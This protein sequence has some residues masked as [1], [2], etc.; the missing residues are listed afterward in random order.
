MLWSP[1]FVWLL[2]SCSGFYGIGATVIVTIFTTDTS[3]QDS[4]SSNTTTSDVNNKKTESQNH[5]TIS[6]LDGLWMNLYFGTNNTQNICDRNVGVYTRTMLLDAS[7]GVCKS[8]P[9]TVLSA[10]YN[11]YFV[12][13]TNDGSIKKRCVQYANNT[14]SNCHYNDGPVTLDAW[15]T[16]T[17]ITKYST[18]QLAWWEILLIVVCVI[19]LV[20]L[21]THGFIWRGAMLANFDGELN[22]Y[23]NSTILVLFTSIALPINTCCAATRH[24]LNMT[25]YNYTNSTTR[26]TTMMSDK[27]SCSSQSEKFSFEIPIIYTIIFT[28]I[29]FLCSIIYYVKLV[30]NRSIYVKHGSIKSYIIKYILTG[31]K[32]KSMYG[33]V[34]TQLF[35]QISDI[36]VIL[37]LY[38]LS[39]Q[40]DRGYTICYHMNTYYLFV[41]SLF[42][43]LFYRFLS[44]YLIYRLLSDLHS[45]LLYKIF[46][47]ILQ[48]FDLSF[49]LTL[50][51]NYKFQ[52]ITP[53]NPQRYIT[54]LEAI[55]EA[56]PQFIIQLFFIITLNMKQNSYDDSDSNTGTTTLIVFVSLFF[57]LISIVSKKLSQDKEVVKLEWQNLN[58]LW[59]ERHKKKMAEIDDMG[60]SKEESVYYYN[61]DLNICSCNIEYYINRII[62]RLFVILNR[63]ILWVLIWRI[64]GGFWFICCISY[65]FAFYSAIYFFTRKNVFFE[66]IMGYTLKD[67]DFVEKYRDLEYEPDDR[68]YQYVILSTTLYSITS[69]IFFIL[70]EFNVLDCC[71]GMN[72]SAFVIEWFV[73]F[74][75]MCC[76]FCFCA[77]LRFRFGDRDLINY[78][79]H[80]FLYIMRH[81]VF[82][83]FLFLFN[84][85]V[86][87]C[88]IVVDLT[89]FCVYTLYNKHI[90]EYFLRLCMEICAPHYL[91]DY[92]YVGTF[93]CIVN[94]LYCLCLL[95]FTFCSS[96]LNI[97]FVNEYNETI[98]YL[99]WNSNNDCKTQ[100][101]F[102]FLLTFCCVLSIVLPFW[103]Y[104]LT[105][106]KEI[107]NRQASNERKLSLMSKSG[108]IYGI[109]EIV[110]FAGIIYNPQVENHFG[111]QL[112]DYLQECVLSTY[113]KNTVFKSLNFFQQ[114]Q[115]MKY[116]NDK[117]NVHITFTSDK[118]MA[119][120]LQKQINSKEFEYQFKNNSQLLKSYADDC[121]KSDERKLFWQYALNGSYVEWVYSVY[122]DDICDVP[123]SSLHDMITC[124]TL[125][126][127]SN[128]LFVSIIGIIEKK[129]DNSEKSNVIRNLLFTQNM[130]QKQRIILIESNYSNDTIEKYC[131]YQ[132]EPVMLCCIAMVFCLN[133]NSFVLFFCLS[134]VYSGI[135]C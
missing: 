79:F 6:Q 117:Y 61:S 25:H 120:V 118:A 88:L 52:N 127:M 27:E 92:N 49:V 124:H 93:H 39:N 33:L 4:P 23:L 36:S 14:C 55:F 90:G 54:N 80:I 74:G 128:E 102:I 82:I 40:E 135:A 53:C 106:E 62:W 134:S 132:T 38:F 35:D 3:T 51:I 68:F 78:I 104:F 12:S 116:L 41:S 43:F 50:K 56:A 16:N 112:I 18:K 81:I 42:V 98:Y 67:V 105:F 125:R 13:T 110:E 58:F 95:F 2:G 73:I 5:A 109:C 65:E 1:F 86:F 89:V 22:D 7:G 48:F 8:L 91:Y 113:F 11:Y 72:T 121:F 20:G 64:I 32:F 101:V 17:T 21:S 107:I 122:L 126:E 69:C 75:I 119:N 115:I 76:I 70:S 123:M 37:Q 59:G 47:T 99:L 34:F 84:Y 77:Y 114:Y 103:T 19:K 133:F 63:L 131:S 30:T 10:T 24:G 29:I 9:I 96:S 100:T 108:D 94:V 129:L 85:Y 66:S 83:L 71:I 130:S 60:W 97:L 44:S 28:S 31:W 45:P 111:N 87:T 26:T 15:N 57:S 46:L